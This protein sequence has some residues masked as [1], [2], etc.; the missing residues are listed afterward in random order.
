MSYQTL[1]KTAESRRSI[2]VLNKDLPVSAQEVADIVKH[3]VLHTPS[4]FNS[5]S[6]RVVVLFGT[7]HDKLWQ[8]AE[9]ALRAI[10]P[11]DK[12]EPTAQKLALFKA[13]AGTVLFFEDG[14][15]VKGLQEQF[16]SYAENFPVWAE[17]AN[18]MHQYAVW[19]TLAA[20]GV[21]A[22]LQHYNPLIDADVAR[23][24]NIPASWSLRAQMVFGGIGAQADE[25]T[26]APVEGRF[27]V[28]GL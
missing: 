22:N 24:W 15:V 19:T 5:Q 7:E 26:F 11:A 16:P 17:H 28:Y 10:V 1:Q 12:F 21:G 14:D 9:N 13:A 8:F 27:A 20:A 2:Y 4:S 25:K 6:T 18:A 23:E 3:A